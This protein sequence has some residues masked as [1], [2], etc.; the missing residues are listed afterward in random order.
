V[1]E[2]FGELL[3]FQPGRKPIKWLIQR[4]VLQ[5]GQVNISTEVH[6]E[7]STKVLKKYLEA[8]KWMPSIP[9]CIGFSVFAKTPDNSGIDVN[10]QKQI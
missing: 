6:F 9:N 10:T 7:I 2:N 5:T 8:E 1:T 3:P 4:K